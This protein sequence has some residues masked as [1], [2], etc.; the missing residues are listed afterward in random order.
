MSRCKTPCRSDCPNRTRGDETPNCH[1]I[2]PEYL[3]FKKEIEEE[4]TAKRE[5]NKAYREYVDYKWRKR[6]NR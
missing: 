2:C 4:R 1:S 6:N 5:H 3:A